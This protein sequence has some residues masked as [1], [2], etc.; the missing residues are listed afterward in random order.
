MTCIVT[1]THLHEHFP[2]E[3]CHL[4][5]VSTCA[6]GLVSETFF[7]NRYSY[8]P[9]LVHLYLFLFFMQD[10]ITKFLWMGM[11]THLL[12]QEHSYN[13]YNTSSTVMDFYTI[14]GDSTA[15][16]NSNDLS[17]VLLYGCAVP[18]RSCGC[19]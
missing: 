8:P 15:L 18:L 14:A 5:C 9:S 10:S 19:V 11:Q 6:V 17:L 4:G 7:F 13:I 12:P 2:L 3:N 1:G 16:E